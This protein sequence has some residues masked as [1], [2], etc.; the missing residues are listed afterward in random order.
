VPAPRDAIATPPPLVAESVDAG[1][2]SF[3]VEVEVFDGTAH[4]AGFAVKLSGEAGVVVQT[5]NAMGFTRFELSPGTWAVEEPGLTPRRTLEVLGPM[6]VRLDVA[7]LKRVSGRVRGRAGQSAEVQVTEGTT[8]RVVQAERGVFSLTTERD[9][10]E[11]RAHNGSEWSEPMK[12]R[13]PAEGVELALAPM[14]VLRVVTQPKVSGVLTVVHDG[15]T[16]VDAPFSSGGQVR[17]PLGSLE[18]SVRGGEGGHL[19]HGET[20]A[21]VHGQKPVMVEVVLEPVAP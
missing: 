9:E 8:A 18:V 6:T 2:T 15:V 3:A 5:T 21:R 16:V 14:G 20:T 17:V 13:T 19:V 12:V 4:A 7:Q 1:A 10:V 11:L